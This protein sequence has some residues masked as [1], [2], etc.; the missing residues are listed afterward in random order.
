ML[1]QIDTYHSQFHSHYYLARVIGRFSF[2]RLLDFIVYSSASL[3]RRIVPLN[4]PGIL[5]LRNQIFE[6]EFWWRIDRLGFIS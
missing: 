5:A 6:F 1:N 2:S 4:V 3:V